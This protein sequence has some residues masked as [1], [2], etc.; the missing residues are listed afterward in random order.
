MPDTALITND[1]AV[2]G[3]LLATLGLIFWTA[4]LDNPAFRT[5]YKYVPVLLLCYFVP[6]LYTSFGIVDPSQSR[7][8]AVTSRYLLPATLVL[9][10]LSIDLK[11][12]LRLGPRALAMFLTGT[13]GIIIGG[14]IA[15]L[16]VSVVSP[17]TVGGQGPDAV[18]RGLT[19]IAGSWIGGGANQA[20]MKEV[21]QVSDEVFS[22][23]VAVD[24]LVGNIWIAVLLYL[25]G[26]SAAGRRH[27]GPR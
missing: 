12:I 7:L 16:L 1:A 24:V 22:T 6:S 13:V 26:E 18:W 10:T 27:V 17:D 3:L 19:T 4:S 21:F 11:A 20:A 23:M 2:L 5:F 15:I 14:P 9:L 25:A 8:Y